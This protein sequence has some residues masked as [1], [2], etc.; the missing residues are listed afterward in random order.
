MPFTKSF[1]AG[2]NTICLYANSLNFDFLTGFPTILRNFVNS[3]NQPFGNNFG[4]L[5]IIASAI[6]LARQEDVK[7]PIIY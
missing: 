5:M 2:T 6:N 1:T 4:I 3:L 7:V